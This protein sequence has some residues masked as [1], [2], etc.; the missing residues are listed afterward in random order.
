MK[1]KIAILLIFFSNYCYTQLSTNPSPFEVNQS[2]TITIDEYSSDTNC[3]GFNSPNKVYMHSGIGNDSQPWGFS[4]IGNWGQDDGVGEMTD[5]G[6]GTW[7]ITIVPENYFGLTADQA[8]SATKMGLVFRNEDGSQEFKDNGCSDFFINVG[9]FQVEMINPDSSGVILVD[10][11]ESTQILAQNTNGN[12]DY[13]LYANGE[14]VDSDSNINFYNGYQF[15]NLTENQ[16]CELHVT[17]NGITVERKFTILVNNTSIEIMPDGLE[18]GI[19]YNDNDNSKA[20]LVLSAPYKDFVYVAGDF[21]FWSPTSEYAMKKDSASDRFW[22]EIDGLN[23]GEIHTYQYW[24]SDLSPIDESPK[25][26]KTADPFSTMV[27]SP[28]DDPWIPEN[29]YPNLPEY[30]YEYGIEREVTVL[31]TNQE[32]YNWQVNDFVKPKKED[33]IIYEVLIRDFDSDRTFQNLIDRIDYFKELNINAIELMPVMEFEGNESWGYNTAFHMAVDKFY[34]PEEKLK[35]FIDLCHQNGIAVILDLVMNHVMGRSPMNRMWM[36]DPDENGW[37]EAS[38][39]SPYFN[40]IATHTYSLGNDFNHQ[41]TYTQYYTKRVVKHWIDNFKIDGIRWDLTKGFTQNCT[42][43]DYNCTNTYQQDRVD[44][45]KSYADYS[46]SLDSDHYVIFEHLGGSS[47]EQQWANYRLDEGKGIMLWG[48]TN[49][50]Y[51]QLAMGY[52]S[53]SNFSGIGHESRGFQGKRLLGYFESHDEERIMYKALQYGNNWDGY[54]VQ[55]LNT[56]LSRMPAIG[57]ISLTIPG[58]K[59]IWHFSDL[60]MENSLFTCYDGSVDEP[61]C[62]LDTKPQPQWVDNWLG[63]DNRKEIYDNWS[64]I[65][66]LKINEDVFEGNYSITS[67]GLTPIIYLWNDNIASSELKNVVIIANFDVV[68]QTI[69]PYFPYTGNWF[70][71]M[72]IDGETTININSTSDQITLQPGEFKIYGNQAS[73]TLSNTIL[74]DVKLILYPNPTTGYI[75]INKDVELIEIYDVTGKKL[76]AFN[77]V[78]KNQQL[79][80]NKLSSGYYISKIYSNASVVSQNFIKK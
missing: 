26:V 40:E 33:L 71:L 19:N 72:D 38:E 63:N 30:P 48:K 52:G 70:D 59:M 3:N 21:N 50:P 44:V 56:A 34:G 32:D 46:W 25:L 67:G 31:K 36:N 62:K 1:E 78:N 77:N 11:N 73:I 55:N 58:P 35:E 20:T 65:I 54:D 64:R 28:F 4:V 18:D 45:L 68:A 60:G 5:N 12:A 14:L 51:Y 39:E 66:N 23:E 16:Y 6:D 8:V 17:Q 41:S 76:L 49:T 74:D 37:G 79:D 69:T 80:I 47:E 42:T 53:D 43:Q 2:V 24:V 61:D 27:L 9:S 7:S 75:S 22:L 13:E 57:A 29:S 15:N 10:Y